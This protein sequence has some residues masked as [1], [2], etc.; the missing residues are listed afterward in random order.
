LALTF[1]SLL[2]LPIL[3]NIGWQRLFIPVHF[4]SSAALLGSAMFAMLLGHWYL[5]QFDLDKSLLKRVCLIYCW[6]IGIRT[7]VIFL[8][9]FFYW[10]SQSIEPMLLESLIALNGHG[11]FFWMRMIIGLALPLGLSFMIYSTAKMGANQSCTGLLY[12]AVLFVL[13]GEM[14]SRYVFFLKGIPI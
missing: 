13:M 8:S 12:I 6:A 11:I 10:Q 3:E 7:L 1:D 9:L 14:V 2:Y 5:V 4:L